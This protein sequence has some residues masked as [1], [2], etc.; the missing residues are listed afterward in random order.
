MKNFRKICL[1]LV[2]QYMYLSLWKSK[3]SESVSHSVMSHS[4]WLQG[5]QPARLLCPRNSPVKSTGTDSLSFFQCIFPAQGLNLG[6]LHCGQIL[7]YLSHRGNLLIYLSSINLSIDWL[8][9]IEGQTGR[10][11]LQVRAD[12]SVFSLHSMGQQV[13]SRQRFYVTVFGEFLLLQETSK[14]LNMLLLD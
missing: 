10:L 6:L 2:Q 11:E 1:S 8:T 4:L 9:G 7:Y 3:E 5:L 13:R 14:W 12:V